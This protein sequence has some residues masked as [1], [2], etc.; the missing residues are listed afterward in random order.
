[1]KKFI[2]GLIKSA[3]AAFVC[4]VALNMGTEF[5]HSQEVLKHP[6]VVELEDRLNKDAAA[7]I[8][9]RF[10]EVP[11]MVVV[12]VDPLRRDV[13]SQRSSGGDQSAYL[14][15]FEQFSEEE[16]LRDEWDNV[17]VPLMALLNR[18]KR[19]SVQLSVPS[20]LKEKDIDELKE[21][22]FNVLHLTP[23]RDQIEIVRREWAMEQVPWLAVYMISA[24]LLALLLGLLVINRSSAN[25]IARALTEMK[26]QSS[27]SASS[28]SSLPPM[29]FDAEKAGPK[30][31][32]SQEVKFNDP[33]KMK[34]LASRMVQYLA[35]NKA[36]PTHHDVFLLD[37][38]GKE[39][40][41][42]LGAILHEFASE[43]QSQLFRLSSGVHWIEAL[44]EPGFL[45]F[46]CIE[47]LQNL[48]Q[49]SRDLRSQRLSEAVLAVW[50][51]E[52]DSR[53]RFLKGLDR[54]LAF[55]LLHEMPKSVA[56]AE[57]RKA[58]P[59]A[60]GQM[61]EPDYKPKALSDEALKKIFQAA[62]EVQPLQ[63]MSVVEKYKS[64]KEL[65]EYVRTTDPTEER[66][67]YEAAGELSLLQRM[68]PPFY[69]VFQLEGPLLEKL[70][71]LVPLDQWAL[72]LFNVIKSE[73][74]VISKALSEKQQFLLIERFKQ[75]DQKAPTG[76]RI[77]FARE[78][79]A[80]KLKRVTAE[81]EQP[82]EPDETESRSDVAA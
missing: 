20:Q 33:I 12:R 71:Q 40:P 46:S 5:A 18:V 28:S 47:V 49:N 22:I 60:W 3:A 29:Q 50:R 53:S 32:Q 14:P 80:V 63:E 76:E 16:E 48:S 1:M 65:L 81:I 38:F 8:K 37:H 31:S 68:R 43:T 72:A 17:E 7:Y 35:E 2:D 73:R 51:L 30:S 66:E 11:Y 67:V 6:R 39:N 57:A 26:M 59:G 70:V 64:E 45:D 54:E 56:V 23:A 42:Q 21:G 61:L 77:A 44:N 82:S 27:S 78:Q 4:V 69:P 9:A 62:I 15:Y 25:R 75:F 41:H 24:T 34:E 79:I 74:Q 36:F 55:A 10:P 13:R 19:I 58:F 52:G